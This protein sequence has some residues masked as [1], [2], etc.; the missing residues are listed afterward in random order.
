MVRAVAIVLAAGS[1]ERLGTTVPKAFVPLAGRPMLSRSAA[2]ALAIPEIG[3]VVAA[4]PPGHEDLAHAMLEGTGAHAV[5]TGG[6]TR[7]ASVRAALAVVPEDVP[8]I[9]C[10]DA[11]RPFASPELF[12]LVVGALQRFPE[13]DGV[14]PVLPVPD[15]VKR[16][17]DGFV[18][19][20]E[21]RQELGLAQTPQAFRAPVLRDAH[22]RAAVTGLGFTD[23][24]SVLEWAGYRVKAVSGESGNFKITT[25]EDLVRAEARAKEIDR[26]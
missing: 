14:V 23:D 20:T 7:Q 19:G 15:T 16:V 21:D 18:I 12:S 3:W 10:H 11:A 1:G 22:G 26:E 8:L 13:A 5:V 25:S 2:T 9:V 17:K 4:V 24:A 6:D